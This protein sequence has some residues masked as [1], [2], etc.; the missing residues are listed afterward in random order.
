LIIRV[1]ALARTAPVTGSDEEQ[2]SPP[3]DFP[4]HLNLVSSRHALAELLFRCVALAKASSF[5]HYP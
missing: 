3:E 1:S 2:R 5:N 4:G